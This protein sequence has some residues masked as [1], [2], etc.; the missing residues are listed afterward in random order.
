[1]LG[2]CKPGLRARMDSRIGPN[3]HLHR[4][5][6]PTDKKTHSKKQPKKTRTLKKEPS[7]QACVVPCDLE[8][9]GSIKIEKIIKGRHL[10]LAI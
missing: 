7:A 1:M 10:E 2:A 6:S 8:N 3:T 9:D 4:C 5:L